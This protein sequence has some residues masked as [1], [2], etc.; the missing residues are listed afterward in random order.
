MI[1][2]Y[3][4]LL[5]AEVDDIYF[6]NTHVQFS[7]FCC[8]SGIEFQVRYILKSLKFIGVYLFDCFSK[9][10]FVIFSLTHLLIFHQIFVDK[11]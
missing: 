3:L 2:F 10:G 9:F 7:S 5:I 4:L 6:I 8:I 11:F 1:Q